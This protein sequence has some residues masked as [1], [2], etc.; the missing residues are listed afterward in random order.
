MK[1]ALTGRLSGRPHS[2]KLASDHVTTPD[3]ALPGSRRFRHRR[4]VLPNY[5]DELSARI[6]VST[7][8][9]S[10]LL[11]IQDHLSMM[12]LLF[13]L[14]TTECFR[15][16]NNALQQLQRISL[17]EPSLCLSNTRCVLV[18]QSLGCH[19]MECC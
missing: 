6:D 5:D 17:A 15:A 2:F 18:L 12:E 19:S 10:S 9:L 11:M 4:S 16:L 14:G 7:A 13:P 1:T 8:A 3:D